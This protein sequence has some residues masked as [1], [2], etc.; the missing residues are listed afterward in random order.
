MLV[1]AHAHQDE[2]L[3][4]SRVERATLRLEALQLG[5]KRRHTRWSW[6]EYGWRL[7]AARIALAQAILDGVRASERHRRYYL[8]YMRTRAKKIESPRR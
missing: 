8:A 2:L 4:V 1:V 3:A 6:I 5:V 7:V